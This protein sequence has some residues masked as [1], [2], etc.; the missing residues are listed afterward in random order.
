M[1][2]NLPN[3]LFGFYSASYKAGLNL[4]SVWLQ[5]A[6]R[7]R[8]HQLEHIDA[9]LADYERIGTPSDLVRDAPDLLAVQQTLVR[10]QVQRGTAFWCDLGSTLRQNQFK[11]AD[12]LR[13]QA[14]QMAEALCQSISEMPVA[15]LPQPVASSLH[16]VIKTASIEMRNAQ[17]RTQATMDGMSGHRDAPQQQPTVL[18]AEQ[19]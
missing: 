6:Q 16:A 1:N 5:G 18:Q 2:L 14:Q 3:P 17:D 9:A 15:L 7:V 13:S 8:Q 19:P 11:L 12:H 10:N 4:M